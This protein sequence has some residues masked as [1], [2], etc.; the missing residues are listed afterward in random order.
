[1]EMTPVNDT[2]APHFA[3]LCDGGEGKTVTLDQTYWGFCWADG[4]NT[5][6]RSTVFNIGEDGSLT[7]ADG[8]GNVLFQGAYRFACQAVFEGG[9]CNGDGCDLHLYYN[10]HYVADDYSRP[11]VDIHFTISFTRPPEVV[12]TIVDTPPGCTTSG[13]CV[14]Q[15]DAAWVQGAS[16][17]ELSSTMNW[18]CSDAGDRTVNGIPITGETGLAPL[19]P[20]DPSAPLCWAGQ[21]RQYD[22]NPFGDAQWCTED[23]DGQPVCYTYDD[24]RDRDACAAFESNPACAW[25]RSEPDATFVDPGNNQSF[26]FTDTYD[27]GYDT[28]VTSAVTETT[29]D[30]GG[31][32]RCMGTE[33]VDI[34]WETNPDFGQASAT[35]QAVQYM[36]MDTDCTDGGD[37]EI[38]GGDRYTCKRAF[39]GVVD[40][41]QQPTGV[42]L[43]SYL[44]L[45]MSTWSAAERLDLMGQLEA[46]GVPIQGAW[47]AIADPVSATWTEITQPITSAFGSVVETTSG[48]AVSADVLGQVSL[49]SIKQAG[50]DTVADWTGEIFGS[51]VRDSLFDLGPNGWFLGG[52]AMIGS[53]LSWVMTA[54]MIYQIVIIL[55]Q[56]IWECTEDEFQLGALRQLKSCHYVG[57]YCASDVLGVCLEERSSYCCYDSPLARI[58]SEQGRPQIDKPWGAPESVN[59]SGFTVAEMEGLNWDAIDLSEW[60]DILAITGQVPDATTVAGDYSMEAVTSGGI[61]GVSGPNGSERIHERVDA[62]DP[63]GTRQAVGRDLST[64]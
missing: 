58:V 37:C 24:V 25:V 15:P 8:G 39:F 18:A 55:V 28:Q 20:G 5:V 14:A 63:E 21:A 1:V 6:S 56:I 49:S 48:G 43:A 34:N 10:D 47:S 17:E 42:S 64:R 46:A 41:C 53:M 60:I 11:P 3:V 13:Y 36:Q 31:P 61:P 2:G 27:C 12:E 22:C 45:A 44:N 7:R 50:I 16:D 59:C 30:C 26:V 35:L 4:I 57:D 51:V 9:Q 29:Y 23:A 54:Y 33:C 38:F 32:V 40:C 52:D 62:M 19:F